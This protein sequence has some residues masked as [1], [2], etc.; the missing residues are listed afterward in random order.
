M[1]KAIPFF[2]LFVILGF[3][4]DGNSFLLKVYIKPSSLYT[5]VAHNTSCSE[6]KF[7]GAKIY[8]DD[9][10]TKGIPNPTVKK[11]SSEHT[12]LMST[13]PVG[14][15]NSFPV[16]INIDNPYM[17]G[18]G[19]A[20]Q[21]KITVYGR[22]SLGNMPI[23]DSVSSKTNLD[24]NMKR[25]LLQSLE[26]SLSRL[27]LPEQKIRTHE[28]FSKTEPIKVPMGDN[29]T[30]DVDLTTTY[31]LVSIDDDV[32]NFVM[33]EVYTAKV[34]RTNKTYVL[35]KGRGKFTYN[36]KKNYYISYQTMD[37][38]TMHVRYNENITL[39]IKSI[40]GYDMNTSITAQ[41]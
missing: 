10:R 9:L 41:K 12:T 2:L 37:T 7:V 39:D 1:K 14:T 23:I 18:T 32:A 28:S 26:I 3:I 4:E 33:G 11:D 30:M 31:R 35:G 20:D 16:T 22:C 8:L 6:I 15:H 36:V 5:Q 27:T 19:K 40:N 24:S 21:D 29:K 17:T 38:L 25:T 34:D 13:G